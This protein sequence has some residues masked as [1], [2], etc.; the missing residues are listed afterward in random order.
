MA[1]AAGSDC[2]WVDFVVFPAF[3]DY[4]S[5]NTFQADPAIM[6][7][8]P[9]PATEKIAVDA[10]LKSQCKLE[11]K[12]YNSE[13]K[14]VF[15]SGEKSTDNEGR[16]HQVINVSSFRPGYYTCEIKSEKILISRSFIVN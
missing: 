8:S 6:N 11:L 5:T 1:T 13:G 14:D 7:I 10:F 15:A 4:T 2:A 3:V 9:N 16:Y 12:I